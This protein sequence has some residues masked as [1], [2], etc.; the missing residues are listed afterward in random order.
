MRTELF[1]DPDLKAVADFMQATI[2][3]SKLLSVAED[4]PLLAKL[5]WGDR[6]E[7]SPRALELIVPKMDQARQSQSNATEF[8]PVKS[9]ADGDSAEVVGVR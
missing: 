8:V 7:G 3:V 2:Q 9:C 6:R 1:I 5:L 4:L